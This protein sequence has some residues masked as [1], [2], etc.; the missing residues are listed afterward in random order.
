MPITYRVL[1]P[2]NHSDLCLQCYV[3]NVV[4][5]DN[6]Q[7]GFCTKEFSSDPIVTTDLTL[8]Y[9]TAK[10]RAQKHSTQYHFYYFEDQILQETNSYLSFKCSKCGSSFRYQN[11]FTNHVKIHK[12]NSCMIC[13]N[14]QRFLPCEAITYTSNDFTE[15]KKHHPKCPCCNFSSFDKH[16]LETHMNE[17][18]VR[19]DICLSMFNKVVWCKS[20]QNLLYHYGSEH[21]VCHYPTCMDSLIAFATEAELLRHLNSEHHEN[22]NMTGT[23]LVQQRPVENLD[24][25]KRE[26]IKELNQKFLQKLSQVFAHDESKIIALKNEARLLIQNRKSV[27]D[28]Y[29]RFCEI[30]GEHKNKVFTDMVAIMPDPQ[31]RAELLRLSE[32]VE[33]AKKP[34]FKTQSPPVSRSNSRNMPKSTSMPSVS[35]S[36]EEANPPPPYQNQQRPPPPQ[37]SRQQKK[38]KKFT[39]ITSC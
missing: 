8:S 5:Y 36:M 12:C 15:H 18:H 22:V 7:C 16:E 37:Q 26:R 23:S 3:R 9:A 21:F 29:R 10:P 39:V 1:S 31:K 34:V 27:Q 25:E 28:F 17:K 19:C 11:E 13:I 6:H 32:N 4:C 30:C 35:N 2:C 14:S 38:K 20:E 33:L 24:E